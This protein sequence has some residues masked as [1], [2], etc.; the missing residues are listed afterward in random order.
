MRLSLHGR[1]M[2]ARTA[3][4]GEGRV[5]AGAVVPSAAPGGGETAIAWALRGLSLVS[6]AGAIAAVVAVAGPQ[7]AA[8]IEAYTVEIVFSDSVAGGHGARAEPATAADLPDPSTAAGAAAGLRAPHPTAP[9]ISPSEAVP[10]PDPAP[11]AE[12]AGPADAD[13]PAVLDPPSVLPA[14]GPAAPVPPAKESRHGAQARFPGPPPR[15][16]RVPERPRGIADTSPAPSQPSADAAGKAPPATPAPATPP[17]DTPPG[18]RPPQLETF[19]AAATPVV[20]EKTAASVARAPGVSSRET[21]GGAKRSASAASYT[22]GNLGNVPPVYPYR[23]RRN[24][25]EGR[26]VLRV[27]VLPGGTAGSVEVLSSSGHAIL[28]RAALKAV[29][30]WRFVPA[31]RAGVPVAGAIDVP[32]TFRLAD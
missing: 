17:P 24:E 7:P 29:R 2:G 26:V 6:H 22:T 23:A 5:L 10:V 11:P 14:A 21:T 30:A 28:D 18:T 32:I 13:P 16:P 8:V 12:V 27:H 15:K 9:G 1:G 3:G 25:I 31:K 19:V 4:V 20:E